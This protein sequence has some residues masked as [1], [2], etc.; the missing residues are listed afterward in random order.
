M[1]EDLIELGF[2]LKDAAFAAGDVLLKNFGGKATPY[3]QKGTDTGAKSSEAILS[4]LLKRWFSKRKD[5]VLLISEALAAPKQARPGAGGYIIED[6]KGDIES[7]TGP[8]F[9]VAGL[10]GG[11]AY[12]RGMTGFCS[13]M[14]YIEE[15]RA[16]AAAVYDPVSVELF[17]A[18]EG[19]GAYLNGRKITASKTMNLTDAYISIGHAAMRTMESSRLSSVLGQVL[20]LRAADSCTLEICYAA[21][22][23]TDAAVY[24]AQ[25]VYSYA[26][27]LLIAKEAG[28]KIIPDS[29]GLGLTGR[30]KVSVFC[31]GVEK[32]VKDIWGP[33]P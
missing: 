21:C 15:M 11:A 1:R 13:G 10:D 12:Q 17:H 9:A 23:R 20:H 32:E 33:L 18:V 3:K 30:K 27:G 7:Y 19:M 5:E 29:T 26:A 22:G 16:Q 4:V 31:P 28:L 8:C 6:F 25:Q 2:N 24:S 14:A